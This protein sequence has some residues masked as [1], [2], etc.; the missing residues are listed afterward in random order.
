MEAERDVLRAEVKS[1]RERVENRLAEQSAAA[2]R[3]Y[4]ATCSLADSLAEVLKRQRRY[5]RSLTLNSFVAYLIFTLLL[6]GGFFLLYRMRVGELVGESV[7]YR[8]ERDSAMKKAHE[9]DRALAA[10]KAGE[11]AAY[12]YYQLLRDGRTEEA[13]RRHAELGKLALTPTEREL[14]EERIKRSRSE[15]VDAAFAAG[16][17]A[18]RRNDLGLAQSELTRGLG[19]SPEGTRAAELRYQL[20]MALLKAGKVPEAARE[21]ELAVAQGIDKLGGQDAHFHLGAALEKQGKLP[22]AQ[23]SY[24]RFIAAQP[25]HWLSRLAR[26][27]VAQLA[28]RGGNAAAPAAR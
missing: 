23:R 1:L 16:V 14:F 21:L 12:S 2:E 17:S 27:R 19:L 13:V 9:L 5:E 4:E 3:S 26:G 20:G 24:E 11:Q 10:R 25:R 8:A 7:R 15:L 18:L 6:G 22:E 28:R